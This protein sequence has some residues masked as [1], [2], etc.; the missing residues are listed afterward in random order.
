MKLL[1]VSAR[2]RDIFYGPSITAVP[3]KK[4]SRTALKPLPVQRL[5]VLRYC[6]PI[7]LNLQNIQ[8]VLMNAGKFDVLC[9]TSK[10]KIVV[11]GAG[12]VRHRERLKGDSVGDHCRQSLP[13]LASRPEARHSP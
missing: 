1:Q 11:R 4:F 8:I 7:W 13:L 3:G 10:F 12:S 6:P 2:I 9:C 5:N